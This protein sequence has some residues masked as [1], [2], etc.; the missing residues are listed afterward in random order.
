MTCTQSLNF[1]N[2]LPVISTEGGTIFGSLGSHALWAA[3]F[4][5]AMPMRAPSQAAVP[6]RCRHAAD[7][8]AARFP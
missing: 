3:A 1:A 7:W 6:R 2:T 5:R 4:S 8:I